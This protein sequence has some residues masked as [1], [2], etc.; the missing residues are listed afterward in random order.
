MKEKSM[1]HERRTGYTFVVS[2]SLQTILPD[3]APKAMNAEIPLT[4]FASE[5][6]S[7]QIARPEL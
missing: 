3:V 2:D 4:G 6:V 7:F 1:P 5:T